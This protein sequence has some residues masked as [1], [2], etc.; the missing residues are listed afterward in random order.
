VITTTSCE[1]HGISLPPGRIAEICNRYDLVELSVFGSNLRDDFG[2]ES[3]VD[4]MAVFR[5]DDYGPWMSRLQQLEKELGALVGREVDV[6]TKESVLQS[7]NWIRRNHTL[8]SAQVIYG[9]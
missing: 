8:D 6:V 2:P 4:F 1:R 9:P 5:H 3:D 7:E